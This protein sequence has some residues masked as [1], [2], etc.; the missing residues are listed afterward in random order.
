M[1]C[2]H[3]THITRLRY[4]R[5]PQNINHYCGKIAYIYLDFKTSDG[6]G[7]GI[8]QYYIMNK[9]IVHF[10]FSVPVLVLL[11][12]IFIAVY[13]QLNSTIR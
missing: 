8:Y 6:C 13:E 10:R 1:H 7:R 3:S 11:F 5:C 9:E 2:L 4:T 12:A